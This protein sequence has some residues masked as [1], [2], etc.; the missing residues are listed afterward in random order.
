MHKKC[1]DKELYFF[2]NLSP[3]SNFYECTI[4]DGNKQFSSAEQIFLYY[5]AEHYQNHQAMFAII[6]AKQPKTAKQLSK[7]IKVLSNANKNLDEQ[8]TDRIMHKV[9]QYKFG[10]N[11]KLIT[12]LVNTGKN[13]CMKPICTT[14]S[15]VV[16][17]IF[18][19]NASSTKTSGASIAWVQ[20]WWSYAVSL[21]AV[22]QRWK[23]FKILLTWMI[24]F[25]LM[26]WNLCETIVLLWYLKSKR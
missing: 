5:K 7:S 23:G 18:T 12:Y 19:T 8:V 3:L 9:V 20:Y 6:L 21:G 1:N 4:V 2:G 14:W 26:L 11:P 25:I 24:V 10:Q 17:W 22:R 13:A 15:G 16:A